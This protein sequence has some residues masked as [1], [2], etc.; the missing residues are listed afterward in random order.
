MEMIW[1]W[2]AVVAVSLIVEFITMDLTSVWFSIAGLV[3]LIMSAV[4]GIAW[5]IQLLVF[6]I[7]SALLLIFVR[8]ITK[9]I[10]ARSK[11]DTKTNVDSLIGKR[12][13]LL[14]PIT[15]DDKGTI[16]INGVVW[17]VVTDN[18]EPV[19]EGKV[20]EVI[21]VSGNKLIVRKIKGALEKD[22]E[23]Q[24]KSTDENL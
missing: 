11:E 20:V 13:K 8:N 5:E 14:S 12:T 10:L 16:S 22:N 17:N 24:A 18:E 4:G 23:Q 6:I 21:K 3:A 7:L 9:R 1:I 2:L 15:H 19:E